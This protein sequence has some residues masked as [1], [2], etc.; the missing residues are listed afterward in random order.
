MSASEE[1]GR[2]A[3]RRQRVLVITSTYPRH[4]DDY[5]VPWMRETHRRLRGEGHHVTVLAPSYRGLSSHILDGC[6]V[7]RFRYAP[8]SWERL[9][10]EEGATYKVRRR[11]MALL[12]VPYILMGCVAAVFLAATRRYDVI[13]VHWPFPHGIMGRLARVVARCPLVMMS[14]GAEFSLARRKAWV[15]PFLRRSLRAADLRIANSS[16]TARMVTECCD[17]PC[18]VLPY[19]TTVRAAEPTDSDDDTIDGRPRV[20]FTGRLIERKGLPYLLQAAKDL[21]SRCNAR[22]VITGD[23][24][25]RPKLERMIDELELRDDVDMMGFV[26][27]E[28]L[29]RQYDL[30][31]VW[32]NPGIVDSWGDAEGLGIGSIEAYSHYKPVVASRVGGIPDTIRDGQT[33]Y[34]VPQK[35]PVALAD[36][37]VDLI[38]HPEKAEAFGKAGF[39]YVQ[40]TFNWDR[41]VDDLGDLYRSVV[42]TRNETAAC[43][44]H[45]TDGRKETVPTGS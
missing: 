10:H 30:C 24:E 2:D 33:G 44:H 12:A 11:G 8:A 20:L 36:A 4:D 37:I 18:E 27:K 21:V 40:E 6:E 15:R 14:H 9:T 34:L 45:V 23:G 41:I 38:E 42:T 3:G 28:E 43:D 5:A 31:D 25:E 22:L 7:V 32:V 13:H 35:D 29:A 26:S 17:L 16:D 19:G 1:P 39:H